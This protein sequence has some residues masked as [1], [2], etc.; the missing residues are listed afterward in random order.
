MRT[1]EKAEEEEKTQ[2]T[3]TTHTSSRPLSSL[4]TLHHPLPNNNLF[5][6]AWSYL[7]FS[8][9]SNIKLEGKKM[10]SDSTPL[11]GEESREVF[12]HPFIHSFIH[13]PLDF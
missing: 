11:F 8:F 1:L 4:S 7:L 13:S 12:I 10:D 2:H 6:R 5:I 3:H 9:Y